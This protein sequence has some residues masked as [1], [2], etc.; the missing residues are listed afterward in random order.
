MP[1]LNM[2]EEG[3]LF[4][5]NYFEEAGF[6]L[7]ML[8]FFLGGFSNLINWKST[9]EFIESK[10]F[11]FSSSFMAMGAVIWQLLGVALSL[12]PSLRLYG[13]LLLILFT[14]TSSLL[15]YS[16][17]NMRGVERHVNL[18]LFL[19]NLGIVGGLVLLIARIQ[20]VPAI[21]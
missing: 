13:F 18:I 3:M 2:G 6:L 21:F 1:Y 4:S 15:F 17:W 16:F 14:L 11:R 7:V 20:P 9:K 5:H 12:T 8:V 19:T 10:R